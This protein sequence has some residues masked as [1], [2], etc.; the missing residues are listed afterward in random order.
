MNLIVDPNY[1]GLGSG[2]LRV[3]SCDFFIRIKEVVIEM[4]RYTAQIDSHMGGTLSEAIQMQM[5]NDRNIVHHGVMSLPTAEEILRESRHHVRYY[6]EPC[7]LALLI[8]SA[9]VVFPTPAYTGTYKKLANRLHDILKNI[10][11]GIFW[12]EQPELLVWIWVLGGMAAVDQVERGFFVAS[13][14]RVQYRSERPS[15]EVMKAILMRFLWLDSA[16]DPPGKDLWG[17]VRM[18]AVHDSIFTIGN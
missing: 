7:R 13:L 17:E 15:W 12:H 1:D 4:S 16:C 9:A 2:F 8:Y 18:A 6:Y 14:A 10:D 5:L 11:L 3:E